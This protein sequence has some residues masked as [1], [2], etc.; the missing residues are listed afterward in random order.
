MDGH[1]LWRRGALVW[2][3]RFCSVEAVVR[4][5]TGFHFF[6]PHVGK[7]IAATP[8]ASRHPS[9]RDANWDRDVMSSLGKMR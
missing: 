3:V 9:S 8:L 6:D 5:P 1:Q 4:D 7:R 2:S